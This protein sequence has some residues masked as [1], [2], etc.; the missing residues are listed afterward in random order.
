M[1][2]GTGT[3]TGAGAV[4]AGSAG[5]STGGT[6]AAGGSV[7]AVAGA[8][9]AGTGTAAGAVTAAPGA[10]AAGAEG[11][12]A[13]GVAVAGAPFNLASSSTLRASSA[14]RVA[15]SFAWRSCAILSSAVPTAGAAP[16]DRVSLSCAGAAG[17]CSC[18]SACTWPA[19][20][21][22]PVST[23]VAGTRPARRRRNSSKSRLWAAMIC[24]ASPE[25]TL[26]AADSCGRSITAPALMRFT[27]SPMK[28]LGLARSM[29]TSIWSSDTL[30]GRLASAMRPAVSPARTR[31]WVGDALGA[32]ARGAAGARVAGAVTGGRGCAPTAAGGRTG[33]VA[34][35]A[36][37][38]ATGTAARVLGGSM[39]KV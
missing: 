9:S 20:S 34:A 19:A 7:A 25:E 14:T 33:C 11:V 29:A 32:A 31:T 23:A 21:R 2:A 12:A 16:L 24:R 22:L 38:G 4:A 1:G 37:T 27:L 8:V 18:T 15:A 26:A 17:F 36:G 39:S 6:V 35:A 5:A 3:G 30:A 28:A 10:S 13:P